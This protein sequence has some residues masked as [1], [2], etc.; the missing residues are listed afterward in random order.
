MFEEKSFL[1]ND[2]LQHPVRKGEFSHRF[3]AVYS[4]IPLCAPRSCLFGFYPAFSQC[5]ISENEARL[6]CSR[7]ATLN[8]RPAIRMTRKIETAI[9]AT[10]I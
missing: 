6:P 5:Q 9:I 10:V 7:A 2:S 1:K 3:S 4:C 8:T